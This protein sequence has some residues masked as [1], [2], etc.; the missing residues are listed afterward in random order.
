MGFRFDLDVSRQLRFLD[1][2]SDGRYD[3]RWTESVA[4]IVLNDQN[5]AHTAL[6]RADDRRQIRIENIPAFHDQSLH[7]AY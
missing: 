5:G 7:P 1:L 6:L 3:H 4:D 2:G